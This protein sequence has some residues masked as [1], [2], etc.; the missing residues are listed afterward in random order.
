M[1]NDIEN[2]HFRV[3]VGFYELLL[4]TGF[5][6]NQCI[7]LSEISFFMQIKAMLNLI[8]E[9]NLISLKV[10]IVKLTLIW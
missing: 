7:L 2:I 8:A 5:H 6:D 1:E 9:T 10:V 4:S 3:F